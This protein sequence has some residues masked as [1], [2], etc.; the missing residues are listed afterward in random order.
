M[1]SEDHVGPPGFPGTHSWRRSL[2][3][4]LPGAGASP[5]RWLCP[6]SPCQAAGA[7]VGGAAPG[8][9]RPRA[10]GHGQSPACAPPLRSRAE[11]GFGSFHVTLRGLRLDQE[12]FICSQHLCLPR[13]GPQ[14]GVHRLFNYRPPPPTHTQGEKSD[15][16]G[17]EPDTHPAGLPSVPRWVWG[18]STL[19]R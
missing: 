7:G 10:L 3:S 9:D 5:R 15:H 16:V 19:T 11:N 13:V 12:E 6:A 17:V 1:K 14:S 2:C 8:S 18:G 4:Q